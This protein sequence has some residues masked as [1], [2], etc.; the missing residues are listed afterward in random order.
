MSIEQINVMLDYGGYEPVRGHE[1]D[2]GLDLRTPEKVVIPHGGSVSID[3][4]TH[5][6]IPKGFFGK[7][8]SKS[9]LN[10]KHDV[11][12]LGGTIDSGYTG[13]IV[14]KLYNLGTEDYV[15][16]EGDKCVQLIIMPCELP[17]MKFVYKLKPTER[18]DGGFGSTGR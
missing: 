16:E 6:E 5:I 14:A 18:A 12:C 9:G 3:T 4:K 7:L 10:V 11:V 13:S 2:A 15:L 8:E 1:A 17:E